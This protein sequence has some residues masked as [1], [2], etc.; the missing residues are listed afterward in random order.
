MAFDFMNSEL[1][2]VSVVSSRACRGSQRYQR[3]M[4]MDRQVTE[5]ISIRSVRSLHQPL[6]MS[7]GVHGGGE[8]RPSVTSLLQ[9]KPSF[10]KKNFLVS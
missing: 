3:D 8:F 9:S 10:W 4:R 6:F 7:G 1:C 5:A 2:G